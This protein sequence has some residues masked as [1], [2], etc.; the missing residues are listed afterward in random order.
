MQIPCHLNFGSI[1]LK[2]AVVA[3]VLSGLWCREGQGGP[4]PT[5]SDPEHYLQAQPCGLAANVEPGP[6]QH[7]IQRSLPNSSAAARPSSAFGYIRMKYLSVR[8][9]ISRVGPLFNTCSIS[10]ASS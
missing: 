8:F 2:L 9:G 10:A 6:E 7:L 3:Q 4:S 1:F 5:E